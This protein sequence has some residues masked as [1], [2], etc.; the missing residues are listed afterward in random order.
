MISYQFKFEAIGTYWIIDISNYP[1]SL[2][3]KEIYS[4][5]TSRIEKF[6]KNYSRFRQDSL[7]IEMANKPGLYTLPDDAE[8]ILDL[9]YRFY[10]ITDGLFTPL[11]GDT[12]VQAGYDANYSLKPN[13][14]VSPQDWDSALDYKFPTLLLKQPVLLDFGACGKGYLIEI[15]GDLLLEN[16][17]NSFCIDAGGD[18]LHRDVKNEIKIG[19]ED[20][21]NTKR[22]IGITKLSNKAICSSSGNRRAWGG[23][24]HIINPKTLKSPNEVFATWVVSESAMVA[25]ALS[26]CLFLEE[27]EKYLQYFDFEYLILYPDYSIKQSS[28]FNSELFYNKSISDKTN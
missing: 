10:K 1:G 27:P 25:D 15:I 20:P 18:I 16:K 21:S 2:S 9:Y 22:V 6:D 23:Y 26:T 8:K 5:I 19:L 24:H 4:L 28:E 12:L 14:L 3:E 7:V 17:I 13:R 11:I